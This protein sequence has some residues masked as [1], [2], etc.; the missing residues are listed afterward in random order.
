MLNSNFLVSTATNGA[1]CITKEDKSYQLKGA[2]KHYTSGP[3]F[4]NMKSWKLRKATKMAA[5]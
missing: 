1:V 4:D 3:G 2:V 5:R